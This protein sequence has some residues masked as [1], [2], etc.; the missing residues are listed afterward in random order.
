[1]AKISKNRPLKEIENL[2][3]DRL[4]GVFQDAKS[5]KEV[6]KIL[7]DLLTPSEKIIFG[8][9]L[10]IAL[11]LSR[12][13]SYKEISNL[14]K[15]SAGTINQVQN[16]IKRKGEGYNQI[17]KPERVAK[18]DRVLDHLDKMLSVM[19]SKSGSGRWKFLNHI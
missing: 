4:V 10:T 12:G 3:W 7:D 16:A 11:F 9:R 18:L 15:V 8:K 17:V 14:L 2:I 6:K 19:P 5:N 1:M 13:L